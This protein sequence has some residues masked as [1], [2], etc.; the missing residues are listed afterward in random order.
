MAHTRNVGMF[1]LGFRYMA[2]G[3]RHDTSRIIEQNVIQI[4]YGRKEQNRERTD[5]Y[6]R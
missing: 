6:S 2:V 5:G 3:Q 1:D 4:P